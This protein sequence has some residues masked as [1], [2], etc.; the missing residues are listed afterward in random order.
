MSSARGFTLPVQILR[1]ATEPIRIVS[2]AK[3]PIIAAS[4]EQT[5]A[6]SMAAIDGRMFEGN[7][8]LLTPKE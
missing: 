4:E 7:N 8:L 2:G 6:T 5:H 3:T 1:S